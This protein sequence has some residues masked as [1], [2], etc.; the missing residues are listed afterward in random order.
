VKCCDRGIYVNRTSSLAGHIAQSSKPPA[1]QS[2]AESSL[3]FVPAR[4]SHSDGSATAVWTIRDGRI[5]RDDDVQGRL[6]AESNPPSGLI[7]HT[8]GPVEGGWRIVDVWGSVEDYQ[9][10]SDERIG[11]AVMAFAQE[12]GI[13]PVAPKLKVREL[14]D[15]IRP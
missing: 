10:F 11:P 9:R 14:Y 1:G 12:A 7:V 15:V 2:V 5:V 13:E 3:L 4:S 8:S 6:D